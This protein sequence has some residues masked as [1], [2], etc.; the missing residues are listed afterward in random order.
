[1]VNSNKTAEINVMSAKFKTDTGV[2]SDQDP[3][4][5]FV[6]NGA[7]FKTA[8]K[9]NAGAAAEWN[10]VFK[11][12]T[13]KSPNTLQFTAMGK[14]NSTD[15]DDFIGESQIVDLT[16]VSVGRSAFSVQLYDED[17]VDQGTLELGISI[18]EEYDDT[19]SEAASESIA[20]TPSKQSESSGTFRSSSK[21]STDQSSNVNKKLNK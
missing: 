3:Y 17:N 12:G 10:E 16:Q 6:Y 15:D 2:Y 8:T 13:M 14:N 11:L 18:E 19:Y 20:D 7:K 9:R 4:I 21:S 5:R 1:M